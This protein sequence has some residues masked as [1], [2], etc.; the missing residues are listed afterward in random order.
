MTI[1]TNGNGTVT[2]KVYDD[3]TNTLITQGV[4]SGGTNPNWT[5]GCTAPGR[6]ATAQYPPITAAGS[7]GV[8]GDFDNFN[9]DNF[10]VTSF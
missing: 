2:L 3:D 10:T 1:Q 7:V 9:F 5:S 4:D 6:Y 8:R